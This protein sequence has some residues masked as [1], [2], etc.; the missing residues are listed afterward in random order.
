ATDLKHRRDTLVERLRED[1]QLDLA[2]LYQKWS[3]IEDRGSKIDNQ[4]GPE[5]NITGPG[6]TSETASSHSSILDVTP[7][8]ANEEIAELRRK[9]NRLGSVNLDSLQELAELETR[10]TSL[11]VQS[12]DLTS[13]NRSLDEII[14]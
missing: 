6:C 7:E 11:Q 1:Y 3:K 13:A 8:A 10:A 9:L 14:A 2:A 12:D 5:K 4:E